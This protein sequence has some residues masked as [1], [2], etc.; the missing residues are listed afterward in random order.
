MHILVVE[1]DVQLA[2]LVSSALTESGHDPIFVHDGE[3]ALDKAKEAPFDLIV[4]DI[5]LPGMDGFDVLRHLRSQ[6]IAS[7]VLIL[8][9]RGEVK[10]RVT[11]LQ[12]GADDYL[13]KPFVMRELVARVNALGRRYSEE[14]KLNLR[15]GDLTLDVVNHQVHR[16]SR[17]IELSGRELMLLKV[18]MREPGRVFTRTEL[19]E[20]VWEHAHEHDTKLVEVFITRL[21]KSIGDP[22]LI[23]TVRYVG[24]TICESSQIPASISKNSRSPIANA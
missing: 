3:R 9:G 2:R 18:L 5:V 10:D 13:P 15:V 14:P 23:H 8:T 4:L 20:R 24:Y 21:R 1:D 16:G 19:C 11:G 12:L 17:R 6:H 22:P 7:R